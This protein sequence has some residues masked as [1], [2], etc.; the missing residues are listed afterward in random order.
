MSMKKYCNFI[1]VS[2]QQWIKEEKRTV[3]FRVHL[4]HS[5]WIPV[6]VNEGFKFH[7]ARQEYVTLYRW[8][9]THE[10]CNVPHYAHTNLGVGAFVYDEQSNKLLT[11]KEKYANRSAMW[12]LPGGYVEPGT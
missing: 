3:W 7:H 5:E 8:I 12:K 9:V 1:A 4:S 2:L 6:L 11:I 10:E